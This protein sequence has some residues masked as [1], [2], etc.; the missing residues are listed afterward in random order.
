MLENYKKWLVS[1]HC[2]DVSRESF[3]WALCYPQ[4]GG[5]K[6]IKKSL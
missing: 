4:N 3:V 5:I 2:R 6:K 1:D